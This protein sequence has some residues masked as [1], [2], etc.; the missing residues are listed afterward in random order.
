MELNWEKFFAR[1]QPATAGHARLVLSI[2]V[3]FF[4]RKSVHL[5]L[6]AAIKSKG[7]QRDIRWGMARKSQSDGQKCMHESPY[8]KSRMS[9]GHRS[10]TGLEM[11]QWGLQTVWQKGTRGE[12]CPPR[13]KLNWNRVDRSTKVRRYTVLGESV[14]FGADLKILQGDD[15]ELNSGNG[16]ILYAFQEMSWIV[17]SGASYLLQG[18]EDSVFSEVPLADWLIL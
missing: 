10:L 7:S 18:F 1:P 5:T 6:G 16:T 12:K 15:S 2:T 8:N 9:C 17:Q 13:S 4:L 3:P 14:R 11:F